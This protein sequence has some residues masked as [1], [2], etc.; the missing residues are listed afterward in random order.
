MRLSHAA[1][2]AIATSREGSSGWPT[3]C[4]LPQLA[5]DGLPELVRFGVGQAQRPPGGA[6]ADAVQAGPAVDRLTRNGF[7]L[8]GARLYVAKVGTCG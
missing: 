1:L 5:T 8:H 2:A 6:S 7:A 3:V 4:S